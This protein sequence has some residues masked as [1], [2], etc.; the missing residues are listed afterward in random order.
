[1]H[2][3][4]PDGFPHELSKTHLRSYSQYW[5]Y[6]LT[7]TGLLGSTKIVAGIIRMS[8]TLVIIAAGV[9]SVYYSLYSQSFVIEE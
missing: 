3:P 7:E 6:L 1:V 5:N 9:F 2:A 8:G 4:I